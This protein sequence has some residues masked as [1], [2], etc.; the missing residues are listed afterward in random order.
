MLLPPVRHSPLLLTGLLTL[1]LA[2]Y[3]RGLFGGFLFDDYPNIVDNDFLLHLD[4]SWQSWKNAALSSGAGLLRRPVSMLSFALNAYFTGMDPAAFKLFNVFIHLI[5]GVLAYRLAL[6]LIP[7]LATRNGTATQLSATSQRLLAL[8]VAAAWLLHP[9]HVSNV[10][11]VV[12]RMNLLAALFTLAALLCYTVMR[13]RQLAGTTGSRW[14]LAGFAGFSLLALLSKENGALIPF[15]VLVIELFAF[16]F[17]AASPV[18]RNLVR[19]GLGLCVGAPAVF[20]IVYMACNPE[21][22]LSGYSTRDFDLMERLL[23]QTRVFWH[24]LLWTFIPNIHWMGLYHD[25]IAYSKSLTTPWSTLPALLGIAGLMIT[26]WRMRNA[27]PGLCF[28]IAWLLVGHALESTVIPLEMVFEHRQYLPMY[29]VFLGL[30]AALATTLQSLPRLALWLSLAA[31]L[32]LT[33]LTAQR[34][35]LWGDPQHLMLS[36]AQDHPHSPR[37]LFEAGRA[38][39]DQPGSVD[40]RHQR[41]LAGRDYFSRAMQL[42]PTYVHPAASMVM[43]YQHEAAVPAALMADLTHRTAH[44]QRLSPLPILLVIRA[45]AHKQLK[46]APEA[47]AALVNA[48]LGNPSADNLSRGLVLTNYGNYLATAANDP[49]AAIGV[50]LAAIELE[51]R[52]ALFQLNAAYLAEQLGQPQLATQHLANAEL[53]DAIGEYKDEI[54]AL[55]EK[56]NAKGP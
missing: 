31:L 10:L 41:A 30:V 4:G 25:D 3:L 17:A 15:F 39:L 28:A 24:Y 56:L 55:R 53:L 1:T 11:Y 54:V 19:W 37:S 18:H 40:E 29:G 27:A 26:G 5:S 42:S 48:T 32:A 43:T 51:P 36:M 16:R 12:Q 6:L 33:L 14:Q 7:L 21:W 49:Q 2:L 52:Y 50:T 45:A 23:T 13:H 44:M 22:L 8:L 20:A 47:M 35:R 46:I 9:L 38:L 34:S